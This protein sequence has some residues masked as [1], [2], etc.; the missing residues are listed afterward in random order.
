M[1]FD[2]AM[3]PSSRCAIHSLN[4]EKEAKQA[5]WLGWERSHQ[6]GYDVC[7]NSIYP[8]SLKYSCCTPFSRKKTQSATQRNLAWVFARKMASQTFLFCYMCKL[9]ISLDFLTS[10][11]L[12]KTQALLNPWNINRQKTYRKKFS[13]VF[14]WHLTFVSIHW[15]AIWI[16]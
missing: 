16:L 8:T 6:A 13:N 5:F 15:V 1:T 9:I 3:P 7:P 14:P 2:A 4:A 11:S 12:P 10:E